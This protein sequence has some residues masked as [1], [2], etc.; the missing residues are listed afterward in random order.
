VPAGGTSMYAI[1]TVCPYRSIWRNST[2]W[3]YSI[4]SRLI[5]TGPHSAGGVAG[6]SAAWLARSPGRPT[7]PTRRAPA[8][9]D[10]GRLQRAAAGAFRES[11]RFTS[12]RLG[13][14]TV[15]RVASVYHRWGSARP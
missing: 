11:I 13:D 15:G 3:G 5:E 2:G 10:R 7:S 1:R 9:I 6:G 12:G 4:S 14:A 8:T